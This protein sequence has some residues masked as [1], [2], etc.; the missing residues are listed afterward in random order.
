MY[1]SRQTTGPRLPGE[2]IRQRP[3]PGTSN[4]NDEQESQPSQ[5][6]GLQTVDLTPACTRPATDESEVGKCLLHNPVHIENYDDECIAG[7]LKAFYNNWTKLTSD[8][9]ILT[10]ISGYKL[11]F[12]NFP[13]TQSWIPPPYG[14]TCRIKV[15]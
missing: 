12:E 15:L 14:G 7:R 5:N 9:Y 6:C 11:E 10:A 13:P 8:S 2:A 4:E 3:G 1:W